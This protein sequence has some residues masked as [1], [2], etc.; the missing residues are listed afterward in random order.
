MFNNRPAGLTDIMAVLHKR[1]T[2]A[3]R[4]QIISGEFY[5]PQKPKSTIGWLASG[6][7]ST[8]VGMVWGS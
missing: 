7:Y 1:G 5:E 6:L 8:T 3:T 2:L 4:E